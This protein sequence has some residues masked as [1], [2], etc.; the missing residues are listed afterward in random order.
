MVSKLARKKVRLGT[1]LSSI[2]QPDGS[3]TSSLVGTAESLLHQLI[4]DEAGEYGG[5]YEVVPR[6]LGD[7]VTVQQVETAIG[8]TRERKA[9][10]PDNINPEL[11]TRS[12][13]LLAP[14]LANIYSSCLDVGYFP[15][16]WMSSNVL[17]LPK[18]DGADP[19]L[20]KS[21]RPISLLPVLGKVFER[22]ISTAVNGHL[23]SRSPLSERQ[24]GFV[25]GRSTED[26][27]FAVVSAAD[28]GSTKYVLG[29]FLDISGAFDNMRWPVLKRRLMELQVPDRLRSIL[30]SYLADR[31]AS[32]KHNTF[33]VTKPVTKGCPQGSVLGP[34]L[35]NIVMDEFLRIELGDG[36]L[37]VAYADDGVVLIPGNSR[38]ELEERSVTVVGKILDWCTSVGLEL[39]VGKTVGLLMSGRLH[40][41]SIPNACG[42]HARSTN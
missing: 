16:A 33:K 36:V 14:S 32:I 7:G 24:F 20:V 2:R 18:R 11:I 29:L 23:T 10:G 39:S 6:A 15:R 31:M 25:P 3:W 30:S 26:A 38:K 34:L 40:R 12:S 19:A 13:D 21:Y 37:S 27:I 9:P 1:V 28:A 42:T 41:D 35:W 4:P 17:V 8:L 5:E 22:L